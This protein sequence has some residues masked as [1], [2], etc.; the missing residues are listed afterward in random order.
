MKTPRDVLRFSNSRAS[1]ASYRSA[2]SQNFMGTGSS[3]AVKDI[4]LDHGLYLG[5][6]SSGMM[7][8]YNYSHPILLFASFCNVSPTKQS[9]YMLIQI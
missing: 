3:S 7:H 8:V 1:R 5:Y 4:S 6:D 9:H 2:V